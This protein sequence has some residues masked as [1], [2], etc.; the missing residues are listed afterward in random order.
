MVVSAGKPVK[1]VDSCFYT[2][3]HCEARNVG[4]L[5]FKFNVQCFTGLI[6]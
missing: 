3:R 5:G 6:D 2:A 4:N 1:S